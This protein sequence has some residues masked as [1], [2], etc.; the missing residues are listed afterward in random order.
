[1]PVRDEFIVG[2]PCFSSPALLMR[3]GGDA[4]ALENPTL[5]QAVAHVVGQPV[6]DHCFFDI[7]T[8]AGMMTYTVIRELA[9]TS[10][11]SHWVKNHQAIMPV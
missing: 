2:T 9:E 3:L 8:D 4:D 1:M 10:A 11:F 6:D 7:I 5:G